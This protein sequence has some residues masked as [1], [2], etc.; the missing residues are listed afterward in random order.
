[1]R[2]EHIGI[3]VDDIESTVRV[4]EALL[5]TQVY[6]TENVESEDVATHFLALDGTK[7]ELLEATSD[8]SVVARFVDR[9]GPGVHHLA[10]HVD[11]LA[12]A[13]ERLRASG[14]RILGDGIRPGA[15]GK[16][17]FFLHPRDTAGVLIEFCSPAR[18]TH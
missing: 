15:D 1:M 11:D 6:K 7:I 4:F 8:E 14:F 3:A 2:L 18:E 17:V 5:Q 16:E 9:R 12:G 13:M 10:F